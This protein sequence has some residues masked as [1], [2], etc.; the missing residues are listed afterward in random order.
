MATPVTAPLQVEQKVILPHVSWQLYEHILA[1]HEDVCNLRFAYDRGALEIMVL[2]FAHEQLNRLIAD[3]FGALADEL[4][5]DYINAGSTTCKREDAARGFEPD[6]AFYVQH[7]EEIRGK[8]RLDPA[9]DP[10]PDVVIEIDISRPSL[11]KFPIFAALGI[12]E[13]WRYDGSTLT[14]F[15]LAHSEYSVWEQS[16]ALAGVPRAV[17]ARFIEAG[18]R[19]KRSEW[20]QN[21]RA[22][23][24]QQAERADDV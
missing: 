17:I 13:V 1:E 12:P 23:A 9:V 14:I 20:L 7:A 16:I 4:A 3:I 22:W 10:P 21:V 18:K 24:Q 2:S 19:L 5:I 15:R 8:V 6:T 11:N